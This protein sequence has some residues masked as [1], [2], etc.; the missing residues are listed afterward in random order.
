MPNV[1]SENGL[2]DDGQVDFFSSARHGDEDM[3][4]MVMVLVY[5]FP[6][7]KAVFNTAGLCFHNA[8]VELL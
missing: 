5:N 2:V 6:V 1:L 8:I 4:V 3:L 7:P